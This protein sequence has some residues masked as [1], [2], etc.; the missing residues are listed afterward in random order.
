MHRLRRV[1]RQQTVLLVTDIPDHQGP[2]Q[3][4]LRA[5]GYDAPL[6]ETTSEALATA[7][8]LRPDCIVVDV[9]ISDADAWQ[10]CRAIKRIP[11][12]QRV[13]IV[14]LAHN[15]SATSEQW[16]SCNS[17]LA[18]PTVADDLVRAVEHVIDAGAAPLTEADAILGLT[19]CPA[20]ES[21]RIT[22]GVRVGTVQYYCCDSC[23]LCWRVDAAGAATA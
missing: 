19:E 20:C 1:M 7:I 13:P 17:W 5:R 3:A 2:Y 11:T 12:L 23:R 10:L 4:A 9:R 21:K 8:R 18:R 22:A 15:L 14:M 16:A 6:T